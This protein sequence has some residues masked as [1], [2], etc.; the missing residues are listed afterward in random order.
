M[1]SIYAGTIQPTSGDGGPCRL[2]GEA[3]ENS[4]Q[5]RI[6]LQNGIFLLLLNQTMSEC[7]KVS[8][9]LKFYLEVFT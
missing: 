5:H 4:T 3:I 6:R 8:I 7:K 9:T 2:V 1:A